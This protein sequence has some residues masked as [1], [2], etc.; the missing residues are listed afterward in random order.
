MAR[1]V[2]VPREARDSAWIVH[3]IYQALGFSGAVVLM[4]ALIGLL[5]AGV[6]V[7]L[8]AHRVREPPFSITSGR[9]R[10][11]RNDPQGSTAGQDF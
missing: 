6:M 4:T 7:W 11:S 1:I 5:V 9:P 10:T 8:R 3:L 2:E